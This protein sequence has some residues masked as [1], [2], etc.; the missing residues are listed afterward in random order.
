ML[1]KKRLTD[2][3]LI[4]KLRAMDC[5]ACMRDGPSVVHHIRT[6]GSGGPDVFEN[7]LPLCVPCHTDIHLLGPSKFMSRRPMVKVALRARGWEWGSDALFH[8]EV[9]LDRIPEG[10]IGEKE[11]E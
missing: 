1:K 6:K 5:A 11:V 4:K 2:T 8:S 9:S 10:Y 3:R 7:L